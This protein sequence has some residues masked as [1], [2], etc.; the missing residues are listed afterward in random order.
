LGIVL[1]LNARDI[2]L[3]CLL[4]ACRT[5]LAV[6]Q[7]KI[8]ER[9]VK[10]A[11]LAQVV[12]SN[13]GKESSWPEINRSRPMILTA[14]IFMSLLGLGA[15]LILAVAS[16]VFYVKEDPRLARLKEAL[17]GY[18][19]GG[20]GFPG[21]E[22]AARA[23]LAGK[24]RA[25]MCIGG[26]IDVADILSQILGLSGGTFEP[27]TAQ[28]D[29]LGGDRA[30]RRFDYNGVPDCRAVRSLA[31]G[32]SE[33]ERACLGGGICAAVCPFHAISMGLHRTPQ[34]AAAKCRGCGRCAEICP[35]KVIS[36]AG[37]TAGLLHLN[38][39]KECLAPCRQRCPAQINV[40]LFIRH[41]GN[42]NKL[43]AL[44][45]IK[46]RNPFPMTIGRT[47]PHTC[48]N[49]CRRNI[50]DEG[51]AVGHLE[52]Y[53]G[54]WER[55]SGKHLPIPCAADTG[56]R[57]AVVGSGPSG[58]AC[59]Y[60]LRRLGHRPF[61]F[62]EKPHLGGMLRYGI[63][64][65]RLPKSIADWEIEGIIA[66]GVGVQTGVRLGREFTLRELARSGFEA[67]FVAV[68]AW[69][70]PQLGIPGESATGVFAS[71]DFLSKAGSILK[72]LKGKRAAVIGESNTAMDCARSSIRLETE[73]VTVICPCSREEM[74]A[75]KR[76][77]DRA[78]EEGVSIDFMTRP[79]RISYDSNGCVDQMEF[80]RLQ[81]AGDKKEKNLCRIPIPGSNRIM[82][83]DL[84]IVACERKPDLSCLVQGEDAG[85]GFRFTREANLAVD[86]HTMA[87]SPPNIFAAG[88]LTTGRATVVSAVAGARL[89]ARSIHYLLTAGVI[90]A[91][92]DLQRRINPAS[93]LKDIRLPDN[94]PR[95]ARRELPVEIRRS[96]FA[97]EVIATMTDR[98]AMTECGRCLQCG[99]YCYTGLFS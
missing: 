11:D 96:S 55:T 7:R 83:T 92:G 30:L 77:V 82:K 2:H 15:S 49:I 90:P 71:L 38:S 21:C 76:D 37:M 67:I 89:A 88:D 27:Q 43:Q 25:T 10:A 9:S 5:G 91:A 19:C 81:A 28:I 22:A 52:R 17:P 36:L 4:A 72:T 84:V 18:N 51:V 50:A 20:C 33:C 53:L 13:R 29:C 48:E 58:L 94:V 93:I 73:S 44:A 69:T 34:V 56:R 66:L 62:E 57:V 16:K 1:R 64:S 68:G 95:V 61:I 60:F 24:A 97:E 80:C 3:G 47:C 63:P 41:L 45:L 40:P 26:G 54:E 59:A 35:Q 12:L 75:R 39:A 42:G 46:E 31:G 74:S 65:Y 86:P 99:T 98:D 85:F 78:L 87:A 70:I 6:E 23:L 8:R 79:V 32:P 14:A